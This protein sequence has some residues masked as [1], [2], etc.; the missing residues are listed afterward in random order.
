MR[1]N[2]FIARVRDGVI[3]QNLRV[4]SELLRKP[5][6][7]I[8]DPRWKVIAASYA[9]MDD[10]QKAAVAVLIRQVIVDTLSN[11]FGILDGSSLLKGFRDSFVLSYG[12]DGERLN[13][14]LQDLL[15][16]AEEAGP[17]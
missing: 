15:L 17:S 8:R 1:E 6:A 5:P 4:Y 11:V 10:D 9:R 13:G 2:E 7:S 16:A 3:E 14:D 12:P